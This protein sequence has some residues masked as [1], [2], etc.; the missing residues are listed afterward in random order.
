MVFS[1]RMPASKQFPFNC[2]K[3]KSFALSCASLLGVPTLKTNFSRLASASLFA[4]SKSTCT[5]FVYWS[6]NTIQNQNH[7]SD[8]TPKGPITSVNNLSSVSS[9]CVSASLGTGV[10]VVMAR[11][12]KLHSSSRSTLS[13][14]LS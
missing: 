8:F 10:F 5:N 4:L 14:V 9:D 1:C 2:Y 11:M 7:D 6:A 3:Q 13:L 12:H